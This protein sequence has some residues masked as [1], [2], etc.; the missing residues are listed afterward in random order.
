VEAVLEHVRANGLPNFY[1]PQR[2]GRDGGTVE[3][4]LQCL[5]GKAPK[6]I[7]PFLFRF[8]L[9]AVQSLLFNDY[10]SRRSIVRRRGTVTSVASSRRSPGRRR[11]RPTR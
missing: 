7:R 10:L 1:G 2:F 4:G 6:R 8:A 11:T 3:L 9:S 5:V